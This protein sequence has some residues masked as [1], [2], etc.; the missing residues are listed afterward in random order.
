MVSR[1]CPDV[2]PE[3]GDAITIQVASV[4]AI[5]GQYW[6]PPL[7][8]VHAKVVD[9]PAA[10]NELPALDVNWKGLGVQPVLCE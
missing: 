7:G 3:L 4:A 5:E 10:V 1:D 8:L 9:P 6:E 2:D